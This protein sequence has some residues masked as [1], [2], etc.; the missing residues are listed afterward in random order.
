[1]KFIR[2]YRRGA[3]PSSRGQFED[4]DCL[5]FTSIPKVERDGFL[6]QRPG[7]RQELTPAGPRRRRRGQQ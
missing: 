4:G 3:Q 6:V 1:M 2:N 7:N 5:I